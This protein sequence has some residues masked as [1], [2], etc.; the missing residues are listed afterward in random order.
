MVMLQ[1]LKGSSA[2]GQYAVAVKVFESLYFLPVI[3]ANTYMPRV[4]KGDM[5]FAKNPELR[6]LYKLAWLLG[7]G[8]MLVS[9]FVLPFAIPIVFGPNYQQAQQV[10][11]LAGPAAFAVATGC[12][13]SCWLQLNNL[14]WIS[15]ARTAVGAVSNIALNLL[16]IP[17]FGPGGAAVATNISYIASVFLFMMIYN[18]ETR[19]NTVSL[20]L[21]IF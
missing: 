8:M 12:A 13:S 18:T 21:P 9:V 17:R 4:G 14:E 5:D 19:R 11:A 6:Q 2:V 3:L 15:T 20:L 7:I 1:W 16:L 10:V